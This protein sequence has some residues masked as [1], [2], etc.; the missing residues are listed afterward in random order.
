MKIPD[1]TKRIA[2][3]RVAGMTY[4]AIGEKY[5]ISRTRAQ[6]LC[7]KAVIGGYVKVEQLYRDPDRVSATTGEQ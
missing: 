7:A 1:R 4:E 2:D 3:D 6:Q 5:G